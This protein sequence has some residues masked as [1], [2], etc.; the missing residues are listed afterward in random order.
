MVIRKQDNTQLGRKKEQRSSD[1]TEENGNHT[2]ETQHGPSQSPPNIGVGHENGTKLNKRIRWSQEEMKEVL[3]CYIYV[4][5]KTLGENYKEAYKLWRERNPVTRMNIDAKA[6]FNQKNYIL[7]SKRIPAIEMDVIKESVRLEIGDDTEDGTN[8]VNSCKM[9]TNVIEHQKRDQ[10]SNSTAIGKVEN[11][12]AEGEQHTV[13]NKLKEDL[14]VM[15]HK[16]RLLQMCEREKLPKLKTNSKLI[17]FQEEIN[18]VIDELLEEE[19]MD[20]TDIN[21]LI[22]AAATIITQTLNEPSKKTKLEEM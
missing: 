2:E 4:K 11:K 14:Q 12:S 17:K 16:V 9:D 10:E 21:N 7:K 8:G 6:L 22:Y 5:E 18:G 15:W 19:E 1:S 13:R 3:W 20:I